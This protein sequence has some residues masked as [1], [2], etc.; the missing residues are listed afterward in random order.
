V[1]RYYLATSLPLEPIR[2]ASDEFKNVIALD[3]GV[4]TFLTGYD[5]HGKSIA[6]GKGGTKNIFQKLYLS[7]KLNSIANKKENDNYQYNYRKRQKLKRKM[8]LIQCKVRSRVKDA[9]H[10]I[11]KY[12]CENYDSVLLPSFKTKQMIKRGERKINSKVARQMC[13]W[14]HY[15]F[16][17]ILTSK[18]KRYGCFVCDCE[19]W[20]TSKTCSSCG[21]VNHKLKREKEY[22]CIDCEAVMDRDCNAA[23]NI[24]IQFLTTSNER[25]NVRETLQGLASDP[26]GLALSS[27]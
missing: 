6:F 7:D 1:G 26:M 17:Q 12:L 2:N 24:L 8:R 18:A 25:S 22:H 10:K 3:P 16:K 5:I 15:Q 11:S 13:T 20:Y 9:Y 27:I 23:K 19:E 14:S 4:R 21:H